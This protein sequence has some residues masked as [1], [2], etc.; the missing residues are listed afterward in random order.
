MLIRGFAPPPVT[1]TLEL[2]LYPVGS[3]YGS[4]LYRGW[5]QVD[6]WRVRSEGGRPSQYCASK[7]VFGNG[8]L[9]VS[10]AVTMFGLGRG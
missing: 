9:S 5:G 7:K 2:F 8:G 6:L 10:T 4:V 1:A 3:G